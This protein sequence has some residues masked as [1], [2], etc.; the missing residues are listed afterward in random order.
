MRWKQRLLSSKRALYDTRTV[1]DTAIYC[2]W[3]C[4]KIELN[5]SMISQMGDV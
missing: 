2:S 4:P 5:E 3:L 1:Q